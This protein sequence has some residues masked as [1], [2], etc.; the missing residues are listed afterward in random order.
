M[1]KYLFS[2]KYLETKDR[3]LGF[4]V[5]GLGYDSTATCHL[6]LIRWPHVLG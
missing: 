1:D 3:G 6:P 4:G 5:W 2:E